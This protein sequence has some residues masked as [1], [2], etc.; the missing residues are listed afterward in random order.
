MPSL[1]AAS[2]FIAHVLSS[3]IWNFYERSKIQLSVCMYICNGV[4]SYFYGFLV[5]VVRSK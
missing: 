5:L 4:V 1:A 2:F 3:T